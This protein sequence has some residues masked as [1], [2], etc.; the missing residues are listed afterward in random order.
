MLKEKHRN[1]K[2]TGQVIPLS[3]SPS[4]YQTASHFPQIMFGVVVPSGR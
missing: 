1:T 4:A 2:Q 3:K